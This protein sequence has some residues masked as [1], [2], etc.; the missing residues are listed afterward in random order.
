[1]ADDDESAAAH[2]ASGY[3]ALQE[4]ERH[5]RLGSSAAFAV[6]YT[7][8]HTAR[9]MGYAPLLIGSLIRW[10]R[11]TLSGIAAYYTLRFRSATWRKAVVRLASLSCSKKPRL[12][13]AQSPQRLRPQPDVKLRNGQRHL[14][15][16]TTAS[17]L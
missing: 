7:L 17:S 10:P 14:L 2:S 8:L 1:M 4:D 13:R 15:Q 5:D 9:V 3:E 16:G 6:L 11:R 12:L